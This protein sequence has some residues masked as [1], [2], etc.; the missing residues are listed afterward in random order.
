M[1]NLSLKNY[2]VNAYSYRDFLSSQREEE[3]QK[4][5]TL[6][7]L[8]NIISHELTPRQKEFVELYY[9]KYMTIPEIAQMAGVNRS[10]V[11]RVLK[12]ARNRIG[13]FMSYDFMRY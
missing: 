2:R 1:K 5:K 3:G 10:T 9:F 11:S 12:S 6:E 4:E 13:R 7:R 8:R